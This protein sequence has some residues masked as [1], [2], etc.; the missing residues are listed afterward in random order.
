MIGT[1]TDPIVDLF[2]L[3][4]TTRVDTLSDKKTYL[5]EKAISKRQILKCV[6]S[7]FDPYNFDGPILNRARLFLH[8][9]QVQ[10]GMAWDHALSL[11]LKREWVNISKQYNSSPSTVCL[12]VC[13]QR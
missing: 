9:L 1:L 8:K 2:G 4:W 10:S 6:A 7:C 3:S 5:N 13:W 12:Q 11:E